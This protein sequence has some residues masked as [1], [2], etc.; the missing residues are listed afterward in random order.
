MSKKI[1]IFIIICVFLPVSLSPLA[2]HAEGPELLPL[3]LNLEDSV[4]TA[5]SN[6]KAIQIQEQEIKYAKAGILYAESKFLPVLGASF[7]YALNDAVPT[8]PGSPN[9]RKDLGI[10]SGYKNDN[11]FSLTL[12]ETVYNGG[13]N[14][15]ALRQ[16]KLELKAQEETLRAAKLDIEFETKRLFFGILL[17]YET[18]RIAEDLVS[19]AKA[20]YDEVKK[21]FDQGTASRFDVLQSKVQVSRLMPQL[22]RADNDV[23]LITAEFKKLLSLDLAEEVKID[24]K[25][26]YSLIEIKEN[27]FLAEAY[28]GNPEM[29][30]R[31]LGID[32]AKWEIEYA[33]AGWLPQVTANG[34]YTYRSNQIDDMFNPRHNDWTVGVQASIAIFDG[35]STKAK[36]DEARARYNQSKL[37]KEDLVERI[38]VDV[39]DACYNM[40]EAKTIIDSQKDSIVEAK[41]ALRLSEV[42]YRSGVGINLD[43]LDAE[44]AL[45]EVEQNLAQGIYDYIMARAQLDKVMG[46][47]N[48]KE[49]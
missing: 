22:V 28:R 1:Y 11:L 41:E 21:K 2:L 23:R 10:F 25:L 12:N 49:S 44:V 6:N 31:S 8:F 3:N 37:Q 45:A 27:E 32:I 43:V 34:G 40:D 26:D 7:D 20:H 29:T 38:A 36:V 33:R 24:G 18:K 48:I 19:Q 47:E 17:A 9:G 5:F 15:A 13:A 14:I 16:S 39:K 30:L 35:F 42:R 4:C 46:R